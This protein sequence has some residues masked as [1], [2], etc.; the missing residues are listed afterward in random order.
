MSTV[1]TPADTGPRLSASYWI[2]RL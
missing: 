2:Q 1:A